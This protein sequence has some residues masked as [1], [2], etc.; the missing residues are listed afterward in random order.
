MRSAYEE[1]SIFAAGKQQSATPATSLR[2]ELSEPVNSEH[3]TVRTYGGQITPLAQEATL[4]G[5]TN[6]LASKHIEFV[7]LRSTNSLDQLF[8]SEFLRRSYPSGR[9]VIDGTDLMFRRGSE[10]A[11]LRGVM[12]LSTYPLL[13]WTPD[14]IPPIHG[15]RKTSYRVFAEDLSE[16]VYVAARELFE[17]LPDARRA[18]A[19]N[20][21]GTPKSAHSKDDAA[22]A[23]HRPATWVTVVGHRQF[24]PIAV[25]NE[26]TEMETSLGRESRIFRPK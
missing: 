19:I 26:Q 11:S 5:V 18:V 12:L 24:W 1:Q 2:G 8:L 13:S 15:R 9:V 16:G 10:G 7:I 25:L 14:A 22:E 17:G 6:I 21:Y 23:D 3:D 4:F 20:D